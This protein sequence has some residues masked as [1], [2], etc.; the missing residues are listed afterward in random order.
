MRGPASEMSR[1]CDPAL[2]QRLHLARLRYY[3]GRLAT[4][5]D[6]AER[7]YLTRE[8]AFERATLY[9][10]ESCVEGGGRATRPALRQ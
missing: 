4:V 7:E 3:M 1:S 2:H 6:T 8:V 9:E 5:R 10:L